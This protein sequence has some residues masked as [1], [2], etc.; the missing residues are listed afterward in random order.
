MMGEN[1]TNNLKYKVR[2]FLLYYNK[3][4]NKEQKQEE[5]NKGAKTY[6][7]NAEKSSTWLKSRG[8][9]DQIR[10]TEGIYST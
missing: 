1:N 7:D 2:Y 8:E 6:N 3:R 9:Q 4:D 10:M 5:G